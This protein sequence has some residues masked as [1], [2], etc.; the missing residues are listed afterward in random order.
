VLHCSDVACNQGTVTILDSLGSV[1]GFTS[2]NI[3]GDG[4]GLVSYIDGSNG[5]LKGFHC[6]NVTCSP[7]IRVGR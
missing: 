6:S 1:G 3:G 7:F 4:L 5:D 2:I